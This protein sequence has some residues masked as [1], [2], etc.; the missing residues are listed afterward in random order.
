MKMKLNMV[1]SASWRVRN[2]ATA[3]MLGTELCEED[4]EIAISRR[5]SGH[6]MNGRGDQYLTGL[7]AIARG[8]AHTN[9]ATKKGRRTAECL[10]HHFGM[11][12]YFLTVTPDDDNSIL[13]QT[14]AG[15]TEQ[16]GELDID[17]LSGEEIS[18]MQQKRTEVRIKYPGV[19]AFVFDMILEL[20][21]THVI[22]WDSKKNMPSSEH[23]GLYGTPEAY[24][25]S[26]EEQGRRSL[27]GHFQLWLKKM[28]A[29][30]DALF[31]N[32]LSIREEAEKAL[33]T[34]AEN[35]MSTEFFLQTMWLEE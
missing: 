8:V 24:S 15:F 26:V 34:A 20:I 16:M 4:I 3:E 30:R 18:K 12:S 14:F 21:I 31:S 25:G 23:E 5:R 19:C 17:S 6:T 28:K 9:E 10:Q 1:R 7:D 22:G 33:T 29:Q 32:D 2:N 13:V 11:P 35:T 27:H